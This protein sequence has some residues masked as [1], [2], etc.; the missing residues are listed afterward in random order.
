MQRVASAA[1]A[2]VAA[3]L[4]LV[5][6]AVPAARLRSE[7]D[8]RARGKFEKCLDLLEGCKISNLPRC[9][10]KFKQATES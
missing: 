6:S 1:G 4:L 3:A 5:L 2:A 9:C 8:E 7:D 10:E